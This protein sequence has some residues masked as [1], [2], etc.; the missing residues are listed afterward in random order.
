[1]ADAPAAEPHACI[2]GA[3]LA[4]LAHYRL[5]LLEQRKERPFD[6][7]LIGKLAANHSAALFVKI[8]LDVQAEPVAQKRMLD[9]Q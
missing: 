4:A 5:H 2:R 3:I 8:I 6:F 7:A 9:K 1:M